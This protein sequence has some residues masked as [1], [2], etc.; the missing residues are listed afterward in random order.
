MDVAEHIEA[1]RLEGDRMAEA[2]GAA[3]PGRTRAH[4]PRVGGARPGAPHRRGAPLGHR[5]GGHAPYRGLGVGLEEVVGTWPSDDGAGRV[6]PARVTPAWW[7]RSSAAPA[8]LECWTILRAPRPWP[9]GPAA[10][11]TRPP[12]IGSTPSWPPVSPSARSTPWSRPT[13]W[14]SCCV[15]SCPGAAPVAGRRPRPRCGCAAPTGDAA[16]LLRID[17]DGVVADDAGGRRTRRLAG[18]GGLHG[19]GHGGGSLPR[20][21]EPRPPRGPHRRGRRGRAGAPPRVGPGALAR[22]LRRL[23]ASVRRPPRRRPRRPA[24]ARR[25]SRPPSRWCSW[26]TTPSTAACC[27]A[28]RCRAASAGP[29]GSASRGSRGPPGR[30]PA[31]RTCF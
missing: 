25:A 14:T 15:A 18:A 21:V 4:V 28:P 5:R 9:T 10:R 6:V 12:S 2:A 3:E 7:P 27:R 17:S 29:S 1:L 16:W 20:P 8:D 31:T 23:E 22:D 26:S 19:V 11:P 13:G 24:C 30:P